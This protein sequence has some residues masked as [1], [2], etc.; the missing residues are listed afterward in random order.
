MATVPHILICDD[1]SLFHSTVKLAFK[2]GYQF[3]SAMNGDEALV[4]FRK[5]SFVLV[6]LDIQ[7]RTPTEGLAYIRRFK[8]IDPDISIIITSGVK[9]FGTVRDALKL[10]ADDYILKNMESDELAHAIVR[11]VRQKDLLRCN[12]RQS[13]E[14]VSL[15]RKHAL[16][17]DSQPMELLQRKIVKVRES[18][19]NVI[20]TGETGTGKEVV[21][22]SLRKTMLNGSMEPF[23]AIDAST[24]QSS[25]AE[26]VLFG[27]ERGAFTGADKVQKGVFE[28]A[29]GG[30]VYIDEIANMPLDIQCKLLRVL[31]EKEIK[32]LGS[33]RVISLDFRV[34]CATNQNLEVLAEQG[35]FKVDLLQRLNVI[36]LELVP[37]RARVDDI[38]A[39]IE[40]FIRKENKKNRP[41]FFDDEILT[42]LKGYR[43]PGNVR[44]LS[45]LVLNLITMSENDRVTLADLPAKI[46]NSAKR[47]VCPPLIEAGPNFGKVESRIGDFPSLQASQT[48]DISFYEEISKFE[49]RILKEAL[50]R[51]QGKVSQ[52]SV[53]LGID[54][55][56]LYCKLKEHGLPF[57]RNSG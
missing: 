36:P 5:R 18:S 7:M 9:E 53:S 3:S 49:K 45:N 41:L 40:Y 32:R 4:L 47:S 24:I 42:T 30:V 38:P 13:A 27:H 29:D 26:S 50:F 33:Q 17:G 44:E 16:I 22:R 28:E 8:E 52:A 25:M 54:R 21:A 51:A 56:H 37:L 23:I 20:I 46:Q 55:S 48:V 39:L 11:A 19:A 6:L 12:E 1:D 31:Q 14:V 2:V 57:G 43:W 34:I 35:K 10:G 15:Q